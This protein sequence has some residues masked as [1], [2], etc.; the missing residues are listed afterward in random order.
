MRVVIERGS[1]P[2]DIAF[3]QDQENGE[4]LMSYLGDTAESGGK[5]YAKIPANKYIIASIK[6]NHKNDVTVIIPTIYGEYF[7][8]YGKVD[9]SIMQVIAIAIVDEEGILYEIG[10]IG[11]DICD[12]IGEMV[13]EAEEAMA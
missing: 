12:A 10:G 9:D 7:I 3:S 1:R 11:E 13:D 2:L 5:I 4:R 6:Y 8:L